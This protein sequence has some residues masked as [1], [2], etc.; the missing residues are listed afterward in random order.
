M[1]KEESI[2]NFSSRE[3]DSTSKVTGLENSL[4][5]ANTQLEAAKKEE[6]ARK[7]EMNSIKTSNADLAKKLSSQQKSNGKLSKEVSI[8]L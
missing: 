3:S 4:A 8:D 5:V 1:E 7:Q 2:Q 6:V